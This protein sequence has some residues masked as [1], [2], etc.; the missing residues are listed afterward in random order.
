MDYRPG[1]MASAYRAGR[2]D[3]WG[4]SCV[5]FEQKQSV[6]G[7]SQRKADAIHTHSPTPRTLPGG[8][9]PLVASRC[10]WPTCAPRGEGHSS[11]RP[12]QDL[13]AASGSQGANGADLLAL[14]DDQA[15]HGAPPGRERCQCKRRIRAGA[16]DCPACRCEPAQRL[17][18][19][20]EGRRSPYEASPWGQII[21]APEVWASSQ[22][23]FGCETVVVQFGSMQR[24]KSAAVTKVASSIIFTSRQFRGKCWWGEVSSGAAARVG[25]GGRWRSERRTRHAILVVVVCPFSQCAL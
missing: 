23:E 1:F 17:V 19:K 14:D 18:T 25:I 6:T 22:S 5:S 13:R 15:G 11:T 21:Q 3:A 16:A 12:P 20:A 9:T 4:Q 2:E 8:W 24:L 7:G 10:T